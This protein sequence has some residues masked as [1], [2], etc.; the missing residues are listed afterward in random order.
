LTASQATAL[1]QRMLAEAGQ[2]LRAG[3]TDA[4]LNSHVSALGLALQL[5]PAPTEKVI[6]A[7]LEAA[8]H[9]AQQQDSKGL[10][11]LGPALVDLVDQVRAA[12][13]LPPT[14][15]METWAT[16]AS[17]LGSLAGQVGLALA[18]P[19]QRRR[20]M[21]GNARARAVLLD[22]ATGGLFALTAWLDSIPT[23]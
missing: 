10:C 19:F 2:A 3:N 18:I 16:I 9:L 17:D 8:N 21:I 14:P 22:D 1:L 11:T 13:A 7:V 15:I 12:R 5:G 20:E 4:S 23:A 6:L